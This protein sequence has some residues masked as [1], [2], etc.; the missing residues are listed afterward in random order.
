MGVIFFCILAL[1]KTL[2]FFLTP[3][4]TSGNWF[5]T[6][7]NSAKRDFEQF[8]LIYSA[9]WIGVFGIVIAFK[10]YEDFDEVTLL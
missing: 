5:P 1:L 4:E 10:L 6:K 8:S 2:S 3:K 9:V 7:N